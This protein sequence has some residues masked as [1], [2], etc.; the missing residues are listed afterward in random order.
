MPRD[1]R[2]VSEVKLILMMVVKEH[3][4]ASTSVIIL[5]SVSFGPKSA[6]G[7]DEISA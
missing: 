3:K 6:S 4:T 2:E 7:S 5:P 1:S